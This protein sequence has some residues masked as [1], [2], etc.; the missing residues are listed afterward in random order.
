MAIDVNPVAMQSFGLNIQSISDAIQNQNRS[1]QTGQITYLGSSIPVKVG[2][3]LESKND[4]LD[5]NLKTD[6]SK[7]I[8]LAD[9]ANIQ[10]T[11]QIE[12]K[13][14]YNSQPALLIQIK[15]KPRQIPLQ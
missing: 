5:V 10:L 7:I 3:Q 14:R 11:E 13:V 6:G 15:K 2:K 12:N 8:R 1:S 9:I 4:L